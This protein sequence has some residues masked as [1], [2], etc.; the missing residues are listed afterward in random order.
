[1]ESLNHFSIPIQG[2]KDGVH[3]FKFQV[4]PAFF[5]HFAESPI[6]AG[7]FEVNLSFDKRPDMLVLDF[8]LNGTV[9]TACDRCLTDIDLPVEDQQQL[10]FK[11]GL[12]EKENA[13]VVYLLRDTSE[14]NVSKYIYEYICLAL[15][16]IKLCEEGNPDACNDEMTKYLGREEKDPDTNNPIWDQLKN[17]K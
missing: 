6:E 14:L 7:S 11:Y 4:D 12:V 1:M 9:R 8:S 10:I 2:L 15:P 5:Q 17:L 3:P 16:M 13:E